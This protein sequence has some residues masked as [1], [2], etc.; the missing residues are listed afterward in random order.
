MVSTLFEI[1]WI[2]IIII[3]IFLEKPV[4]QNKE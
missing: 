4:F 1:G 2:T 3:I